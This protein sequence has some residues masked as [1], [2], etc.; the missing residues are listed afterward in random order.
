MP[1]SSTVGFMRDNLG[2]AT[3]LTQSVSGLTPTVTFNQAF[4]AS[5][6]RTELKATIGSTLDFKNTYQYDTLQRLTE[7]VQ[8]G[9]SDGNSVTPSVQL[10]RIMF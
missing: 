6:N 10:S 9:Q 2:R 4:D 1:P 3:T 7:I 5:S 8:Q